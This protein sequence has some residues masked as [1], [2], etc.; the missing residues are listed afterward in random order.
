MQKLKDMNKVIA[1]LLII[2]SGHLQAQNPQGVIF[3]KTTYTNQSQ[4]TLVYFPKQKS[5]ILMDQERLNRELI[6]EFENR[7]ELCD[8][9]LQ[10]RSREAESWYNKLL[11]SDT[12]L[13]NREIENVKKE[14]WYKIRARIW[15]GT[16]VVM[17]I[18]VR[19]IL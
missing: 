8:S 11:E 1:F 19:A 2:I 18:F 10:L 12:Q 4:D 15:F 14:R 16:G 6:T 17:G 9:A 13:K 3:P 5:E 7:I